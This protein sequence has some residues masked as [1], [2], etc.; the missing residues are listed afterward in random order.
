MCNLDEVSSGMEL[1]VEDVALDLIVIYLIFIILY[2]WESLAYPFTQPGSPSW[3][4]AVSILLGPRNL[5]SPVWDN[6]ECDVFFLF[7]WISVTILGFSWQ[8]VAC[9]RQIFT[10]LVIFWILFLVVVLL[11][12]WLVF[13]YLRGLQEL[14]ANVDPIPKVIREDF[15]LVCLHD[16]RG[17]ISVCNGSS[18]CALFL[19]AMC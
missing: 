4:F 10:S 5:A 18:F 19:L 14:P 3:F 12:H 8:K 9:M 2:V 13:I 17:W 7:F 16:V 15:G 1:L 6:I 11:I